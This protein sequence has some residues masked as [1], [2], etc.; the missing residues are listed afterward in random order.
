MLRRGRPFAERSG[1]A[2]RVPIMGRFHEGPARRLPERRAPVA[3]RPEELLGRLRRPWRHVE[4][5]GHS[6][7]AVRQADRPAFVRARGARFERLVALH[8]APGGYRG[9]AGGGTPYSLAN[10]FRHARVGR[11]AI[12]YEGL[13]KGVLAFAPVEKH[14]EMH[15]RRSDWGAASGR[16]GPCDTITA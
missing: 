16:C 4:R 3:V 1:V 11:Q 10:R 7:A 15:A 14:R 8:P 13:R 6:Q 2:P 12:G 5:R 9:E